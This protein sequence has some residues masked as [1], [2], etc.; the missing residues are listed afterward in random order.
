MVNEEI[1]NSLAKLL[2]MHQLDI[3]QKSVRW[4][5]VYYA[6]MAE[7]VMYPVINGKAQIPLYDNDYTLLFED[8]NRNR[9][10]V[11]V[12]YIMEKFMLPGKMAKT[13]ASYVT[14]Q[15]GYATYVCECSNHFVTITEENLP[16]FLQLLESDKVETAYKKEIGLKL[17]HFYYETDR[18]RELDTYLEGMEAETFNHKERGEMVRFLVMRGLYEKAYEWIR[19]YGLEGIEP[20]VLVRLCDRLIE[21]EEY[22]E[23]KLMCSIIMFA[24]RQGKY[25]EAM[26]NYLM[27]H[28]LG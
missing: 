13:I 27:R 19:Q 22:T 5:V 9:Y 26:L 21:R 7:A 2:F 4:V 20:K 17:V 8:D 23:E 15:L 11:S 16:F 28:F 18:M 24:F 3:E 10:Q 25:N 14:E 1:A 12:P 6:R